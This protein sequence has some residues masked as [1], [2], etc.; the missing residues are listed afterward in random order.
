MSEPTKAQLAA[1]KDWNDLLRE[2]NN[3]SHA[4]AT[5]H[6]EFKMGSI[7]AVGAAISV[8]C[9]LV[10]FAALVMIGIELQRQDHEIDALNA[11][12]R[13]QQAW[14][15]VYGNRLSSIEANLPKGK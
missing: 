10:M 15:G 9:L 4:T 7:A 8:C 11:Q 6:N 5:N 3:T 2:V 14:I 13:D 1:L 12:L